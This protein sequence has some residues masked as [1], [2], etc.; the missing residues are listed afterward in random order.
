MISQLTARKVP[1]WLAE[2]VPESMRLPIKQLLQG[3][4]YYPACGLDG[5]PV[6]YL[7]GYVHSFVYVDYG[8]ERD[9]V[10]RSLRDGHH[11]FRGYKIH[12]LRD[13]ITEHELVPGGWHPI[14][15]TPADGNPARYCD[16]IT[17]PFAVWCVLQRE[18]DRDATYGPDRISL[19]YVGADGV[20][21]FQALYQG[22]HCSPEV[23]AI[24]QPGT[25]FGF[26]WT[27][28]RDPNKILGRSIL[29]NPYGVPKYL[30]YGGRGRDYRPACW[31]DDYPT[32]VAYLKGLPHEQ[33]LPAK[34]GELGLWM[35]KR[36]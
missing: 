15:P 36:S 9:E 2:V 14:H 13:D 3:S 25:G 10:V 7:G 12:L 24:I 31:A 28:F 1:Q 27:D 16:R 23:V 33:K 5:D 4:L 26:N 17:K 6:K 20:A 30:L 21:A 35:H 19:L 22:N 34:E 11:G 29:H 8:I 18:E 32:E